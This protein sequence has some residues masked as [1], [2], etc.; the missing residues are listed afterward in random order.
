MTSLRSGDRVE[1]A[2]GIPLVIPDDIGSAVL[3]P[4]TKSQPVW[5]LGTRDGKRQ[6]WLY[7]NAGACPG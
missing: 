4:L 6:Q 1:G 3:V 5:V 7:L 2:N